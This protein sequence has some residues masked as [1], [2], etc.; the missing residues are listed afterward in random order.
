MDRS[1]NTW[2]LLVAWASH[3]WVLRK[4]SSLE[5]IPKDPGGSC[6]AFYG[7]P[8]ITSASFTGQIW[9]DTAQGCKMAH[10]RVILGDWLPHNLL[11][12][13]LDIEWELIKNLWGVGGFLHFQC[14]ELRLSF[15]LQRLLLSPFTF[16]WFVYQDC[17]LNDIWARG[18]RQHFEVNWLLD[19]SYSCILYSPCCKELF[20]SLASQP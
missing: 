10:W 17:H 16:W 1:T 3:S 6:T 11:K 2:L 7:L 20:T 4:N 19:K 13:N 15:W 14:I 12:L 18:A 8:C 5:N 9:E